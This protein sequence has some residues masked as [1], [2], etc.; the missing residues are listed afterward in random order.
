[1]RGSFSTRVPRTALCL[2]V[3]VA[4]GMLVAGSAGAVTITTWQGGKAATP[5][6]IT[7]SGTCPGTVVM[8]NG[9]GFATEGV[10]GVSIG[11]VPASEYVVGSDVALYARVGAGAKNGPVTVTTKVGSVTSPVQAVVL[12]CQATGSAGLKPTVQS[13]VPLKA[14]PGKKVAL[15]GSGFVGTT[16]VT[17]GGVKTAYAIPS[18]EIMY[19][20]V[21]KDAKAGPLDIEITNNLGKAKSSVVAS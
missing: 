9:S 5:Q 21:P 2:S 18:D 4:L 15:Y 17:V 6:L 7:A 10:T 20:I 3:L 13:V 19:V 8:I 16:S 1:V 14:K 11:G 12:P